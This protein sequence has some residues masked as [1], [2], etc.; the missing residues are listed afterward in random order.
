MPRLWCL[1]SRGLLLHRTGI[2]Q[3]QEPV[4]EYA[5]QLF[6]LSRATPAEIREFSCQPLRRLMGKRKGET[7]S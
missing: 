3:G 2:L 7:V 5:E 1:D 4:M 6:P